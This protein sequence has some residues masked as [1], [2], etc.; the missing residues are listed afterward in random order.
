MRWV[1]PDG[2]CA[3]VTNN[4]LRY[5]VSV[6]DTT[7]NPSAAGEPPRRRR[8]SPSVAVSP[9]STRAYV[10]NALSDTVSVIDTTTNPPAV[11]GFIGVGDCTPSG[12]GVPGQHPRLRHQPPQRTVW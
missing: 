6:I 1:S 9:D 10:T 8:S 3:Y 7:T 4:A 5:A 2:T 12:G 11:Q